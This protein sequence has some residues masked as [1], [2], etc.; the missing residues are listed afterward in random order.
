MN[1]Q[2]RPSPAELAALPAPVQAYIFTL[3]HQLVELEG[4]LGESQ[5]ALKRI[6]E[7]AAK[8]LGPT[9]PSE[10]MPEGE[11]PEDPPKLYEL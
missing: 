7:T 4:A 10:L 3:E 1:M 5:A 2:I 11:P 8:I 6:Q 9:P